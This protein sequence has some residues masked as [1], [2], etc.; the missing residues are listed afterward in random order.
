[1]RRMNGAIGPIFCVLAV[2]LAP[3]QAETIVNISSANLSLGHMAQRLAQ[4]KGYYADEGIVTKMFDFKGGGPA[5]QAV[6]TGAA[7]K[8]VFGCDPNVLLVDNVIRLPL[9]FSSV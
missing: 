8:C 1:M 3:A 5:I 6:S 4:S 9:L 2:A 7:H